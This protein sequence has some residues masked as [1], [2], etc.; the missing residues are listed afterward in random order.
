M[1]PNMRHKGHAPKGYDRRVCGKTGVCGLPTGVTGGRWH[2][3]A[4]QKM[5]EGLDHIGLCWNLNLLG[6]QEQLSSIKI[7]YGHWEG[8]VLW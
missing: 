5:A 2:P 6:N 7:G 8:Y 1:P 4:T 3:G